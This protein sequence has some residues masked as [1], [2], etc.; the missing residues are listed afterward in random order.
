MLVTRGAL[1]DLLPRHQLS[2]TAAETGKQQTSSKQLLGLTR[3]IREQLM[4]SP[5]GPGPIVIV[6][7]PGAGACATIAAAQS[8]GRGHVPL[9]ANHPA[10]RIQQ[11]FTAVESALIVQSDHK[12]L[13]F[14]M[15]LLDGRRKWHY[16]SILAIAVAFFTAILICTSGLADVALGGGRRSEE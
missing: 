7:D 3:A 10:T 12:A 11:I 9:S 6:D 1:I 15:Q 16:D 4:R 8:L 2:D 14:P 13:C 5:V